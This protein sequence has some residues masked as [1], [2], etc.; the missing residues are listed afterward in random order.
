MDQD[1]RCTITQRQVIKRHFFNLYFFFISKRK[2]TLQE[3]TILDTVCWAAVMVFFFYE[4]TFLSCFFPQ[5]TVID[6]KTGKKL[7]DPPL[8][9]T[10]GSQS[11]PLAVAMEG[12][13]NDV[14]IV[15]MADCKG[16]EGSTEEFSFVKG[17]V[18]YFCEVFQLFFF[19]TLIYFSLL[20]SRIPLRF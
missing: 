16:H 7:I 6:G 10:I 8:R 15:W 11:S 9:D 1:I 14:F 4:T 2:W 18:S 20:I 19:F 5:T 12:A 17:R 13:G 3:T